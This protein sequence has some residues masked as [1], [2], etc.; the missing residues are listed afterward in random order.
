MN[1]IEVKEHHDFVNRVQSFLRSEL[2]H[3]RI[4][5]FISNVTQRRDM[6]C[7]LLNG[8]VHTKAPFQ[9]GNTTQT[10]IQIRT[11]LGDSVSLD[12]WGTDFSSFVT[13][14]ELALRLTAK[15]EH[16]MRLTKHE[17]YP[18]LDLTSP[19]LMSFFEDEAAAKKLEHYASLVE[20]HAAKVEHPNLMGREVSCGLSLSSRS[21]FDSLGNRATENSASVTL[22]CSFALVDSGEYFSD[23]LGVMPT[24][25]DCENVVAQAA[26][27]IMRTQVR[28][29]GETKDIAVVLAPS[30][31]VTL[32][33][34]LV[35]PNLEARTLLDGTGAWDVT[36]LKQ[37]VLENLTLRDDPHL[38]FSP[39]SSL[40]DM[41]GTPSKPVVIMKDGKISHPLFTA[42]LLEELKAKDPQAATEFTLTGH[43]SSPSS[44]EPTNLFVEIKAST[45]AKLPDLLAAAKTVVLINNLTGMSVDPLTG[46]FALDSDGAKVYENGDLIFS[47]SLTLRGNFFE[48]LASDS[49][50]CGPTDRY[51]N[52]HAPYF[53]T[54]GLS[55]VSKEMA[56]DGE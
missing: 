36:K 8:K 4:E 54:K 1:A 17:R 5:F 28:A 51:F 18:E 23:F 27:N 34:D 38:K 15:L 43:A 29:L 20:K 12:V 25:K 24:E 42:M 3:E 41:E 52:V 40:F 19:E 45:K 16:S 31:L 39:F 2:Q 49:N 48:A 26:K 32:L 21:Y 30:A 33:S 46:Q 35:L 6:S 56:D 13:N 22:S 14:Y 37:R 50:L 47:T 11:K 7:T 10:A 53:F 9:K 44:A 55:C